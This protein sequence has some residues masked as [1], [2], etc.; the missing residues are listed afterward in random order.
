[1]KKRVV[2]LLTTACMILSSFIFSASAVDTNVGDNI[3]ISPEISSENTADIFRTSEDSFNFTI[4]PG[5]GFQIIDNWSS[6]LSFHQG[7]VFTLNAT[8][9]YSTTPITFRLTAPTGG[10]VETVCYSGGSWSTPLWA[11]GH[12]TLSAKVSGS[13]GSVSGTLNWRC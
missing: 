10:V 2:S 9:N 1:M 13:M 3:N 12:W 4:T 7:D 11:T 6:T 5:A 8:W